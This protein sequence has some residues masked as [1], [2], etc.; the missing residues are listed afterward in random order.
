M[1]RRPLLIA[2]IAAALG[3][4]PQPAHASINLSS[5][6]EAGC[7]STTLTG[8][9]DFIQFVLRVPDQVVSGVSYIN[10]LVDKIRVVSSSSTVFSFQAVTHVWRYLSDGTLETLFRNDGGTYAWSAG[11]DGTGDVSLAAASTDGFGEIAPIYLLTDVS[12]SGTSSDLY[13]LT[14]SAHG[15]TNNGTG[16]E[17][18]TGGSVTPE[19]MSMLLLGSGLAGIGA[20]RRQRRKKEVEPV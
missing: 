13:G 4:I 20:A 10:N 18:S 15:L 1:R 5:S 17:F 2:G 7:T 9:C 14:Y 16:S 12:G 19:P 8:S 6:M 11:V 3:G